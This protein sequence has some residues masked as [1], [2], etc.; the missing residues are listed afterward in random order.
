MTGNPPGLPGADS[1]RVPPAPAT[2]HH[3]GDGQIAAAAARRALA[4]PGVLRLQP[5]LKHAV[6]RAARL[7][8]TAGGQ[9]DRLAAAASGIEVSRGEPR[10]P[11][12]GSGADSESGARERRTEVTLRVITAAHPSPRGIAREVQ[13]VVSDE[14]A[15]LTRTPVTVVVVIVD[16]EDDE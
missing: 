15:L 5:G 12:A 10:G 4:E 1:N 11:A 3:L 13:R 2:E 6:G 9:E 7:L 14:L 16:V 8:F